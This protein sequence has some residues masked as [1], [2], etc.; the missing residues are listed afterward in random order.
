MDGTSKT[1]VMLKTDTSPARTMKYL[2]LCYLMFISLFSRSLDTWALWKGVYKGGTTEER[3]QQVILQCRDLIDTCALV[4]RGCVKA[5]LQEFCPPFWFLW[6]FGPL[7]WRRRG[8]TWFGQD[9]STFICWWARVSPQG[10]EACIWISCSAIIVLRAVLEPL[11][12]EWLK[13]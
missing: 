9:F 2:W 1:L 13:R 8:S 3:G 4:L 10:R 12:D 6:C 11:L 7:R 5:W